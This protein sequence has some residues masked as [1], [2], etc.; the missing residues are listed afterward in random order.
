MPRKSATP[1]PA[2]SRRASEGHLVVCVG[3]ENA[4]SLDIA[5]P[6]QVFATANDVRIKQGLRAWYRPQLVS[7]DAS[8]AVTTSSGLRMLV[9]GNWR[10]LEL[11]ANSTVLIPGGD[12]VDVI[13]HDEA[14]RAWIRH[15][16]PHVMRLG[17]VCSGALVL[18]RAGLL[19]GMAATTHWCRVDQLRE[20]N[21]DIAVDSDRL[22]TFEAG[23]PVYGHL[24]TS[25]GVTAGIDLA[26]ALV[27]ADLG[28]A[29]A[30][31]VAR[32]LVM[33]MRRP[34]GQA[35]FSPLL[36][37]ETT[38]APRL[39]Q[40]LDWIPGQIGADLSV[41]RLAEKACLPPR[42]LARVFQKELGTT[43]AKYVERVRVEAASALLGQQQA[44]VT[45][46]ARLCGFGHPENLRRSFHKHLAVSPQAF[47]ERF[48]S[49]SGSG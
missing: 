3:Y 22:H 36:A 12:G 31:A 41:G 32:Q 23:H 16:E 25:A 24:F 4:M 2:R 18:A 42:T 48:G 46:V 43:P 5:G 14:L 33:F 39:A 9:D 30:L 8:G 19:N 38:Q 7:G 29:C 13:Q 40:L 17:S 34:G 20:M 28:R 44:S 35:Q 11:P 37:P 26:L 47:A 45:T 15:I 49:S 27:E 6:L 21:P 1:S 10:D